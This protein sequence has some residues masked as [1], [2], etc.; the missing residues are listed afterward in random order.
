MFIHR[1]LVAGGLALLLTSA[2]VAAPTRS[3]SSRNHRSRSGI[4][5]TVVRVHHDRSH[6]NAGWIKVRRGT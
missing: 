5:G 2:L 4:E 3:L 6:R 1:G